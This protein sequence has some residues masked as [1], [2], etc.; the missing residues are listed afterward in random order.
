[1]RAKHLAGEQLPRSVSYPV[2]V[3]RIADRLCVIALGGEVFASIGLRIRAALSPHP[4]LTIGHANEYRGYV[5]TGA[6]ILEGGYEAESFYN[7]MLPA[8]YATEIDDVIVAAAVNLA[9][10]AANGPQAA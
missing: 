2:Q 7:T 1:M 3:W 9:R 10:G 4:C 6:A 8:P 5:P